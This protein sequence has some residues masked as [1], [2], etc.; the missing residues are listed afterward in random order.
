[1][2]KILWRFI[3]LL[4]LVLLSLSPLC[5]ILVFQPWEWTMPAAQT[6]WS[7]QSIHWNTSHPKAQD[8][9]CEDQLRKAPL[10]SPC[11]RRYSW[12]MAAYNLFPI[13]FLHVYNFDSLG[14]M[15][16]LLCRVSF[17]QERMKLLSWK[18]SLA[19]LCLLSA[20][21]NEGLLCALF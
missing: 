3:F 9:R 4:L 12:R 6:C 1:M 19:L 13:C 5:C 11:S 10:L 2:Y 15:R 17:M 20:T 14:I 21:F 7:T 8:F 16:I 18:S